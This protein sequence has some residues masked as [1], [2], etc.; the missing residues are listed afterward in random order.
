MIENLV[1]SGGGTK[2]ISYLGVIKY[3]EEH[4]LMKNGY[5]I[6]DSDLHTIEPGT[7]Y[8]NYMPPNFHDQRP[9]YLGWSPAN[10]PHWRVQGE[11]IPPWALSDDV[12]KAQKFLDA[13]TKDIYEP[14]KK[15]EYSPESTLEAMDVEGI[16]IAVLFPTRGLNV[17]SEPNMDPGLASALACSYNDWLSDLT[18]LW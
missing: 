1:F 8:E 14:I 17:L 7:L 16:D 12:I 10:F 15:R 18:A 13:P 3:L 6:M 9:E 5:K 4:K 11:L 2:C